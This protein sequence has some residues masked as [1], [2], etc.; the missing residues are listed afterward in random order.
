[1]NATMGQC[2]SLCADAFWSCLDLMRAGCSQLWTLLWNLCQDL[3]LLGEN[4]NFT[5]AFVTVSFVFCLSVAF[6]FC[7]KQILCRQHF[8]SQ[9]M[10][11]DSVYYDSEYD[12]T[13]HNFSSYTLQNKRSQNESSALSTSFGSNSPPYSR[14][15]PRPDTVTERGY[16]GRNESGDN[17]QCLSSK[18]RTLN[19]GKLMLYLSLALLCVSIPWEFCRLYQAAIGNRAAVA[20]EGVPAECSVESLSLLQTLKVWLSR[21]LAWSH[22][23]P[24]ERYFNAM[25]VDPLWDVTPF[26]V[27]YCIAIFLLRSRAVTPT[28]FTCLTVL[29]HHLGSHKLL[30]VSFMLTYTPTGITGMS[31]MQQI[32]DLGLQAL[33]NHHSRSMDEA[34]VA[35]TE[36]VRQLPELVDIFIDLSVLWWP[37]F[38]DYELTSVEILVELPQAKDDGQGFLVDLAVVPFCSRESLG[39][40]CTVSSVPQVLMSVATRCIVHPTEMLAGGMGRALRNFFTQIPLHWQPVCMLL[41]VALTLIILLMTC[42][43]RLHIPLLLRIE[44]RTPVLVGAGKGEVT[45]GCGRKGEGRRFEER[46]DRQVQPLCCENMN[47]KFQGKRS[48]ESAS[49][50]ELSRPKSVNFTQKYRR[51]T[52]IPSVTSPPENFSKTRRPT[53][54]SRGQ[55][56][57]LEAPNPRGRSRVGK[58]LTSQLPSGVS[59]RTPLRDVDVTS[60]RDVTSDSDEDWSPSVTRKKASKVQRRG[61]AGGGL[62]KKR[63]K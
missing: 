43:Y 61:K 11:A 57:N 60:N 63:A 54:D 47:F 6:L 17:M 23:N 36:R 37:A 7:W 8:K 42:S 50:Y 52:D 35:D 16:W 31:E 55:K 21:Q 51:L 10:N 29:P 1:M 30:S 34:S 27:R 3:N 5:A 38:T 22:D 26:M 2:F 33:W 15:S 19:P 56:E 9:Q 32:K 41:A 25:F 48:D 28:V 12:D 58:T 20:S 24:C 18:R 46:R 14:Y 45:R 44:P 39:H 13:V 62:G 4:S 40:L 49:P 53:F 59:A